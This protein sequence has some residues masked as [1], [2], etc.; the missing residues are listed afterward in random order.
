MTPQKKSLT[1]VH[2]RKEFRAVPDSVNKVH[3]LIEAKKI[4]FELG[5]INV[6]SGDDGSLKS[7]SIKNKEDQK[8]Y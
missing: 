3:E 2:R 6:L 7:V 1:L 8:K 5:Q 4:N